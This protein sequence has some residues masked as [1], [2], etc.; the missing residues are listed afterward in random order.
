MSCKTEF[1]ATLNLQKYLGTLTKN[2]GV[3]TK[4]PS[5]FHLGNDIL[6]N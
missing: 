2:W 3:N 5:K 1:L 6:P 4:A